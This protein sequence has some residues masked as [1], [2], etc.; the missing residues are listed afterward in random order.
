V[1][2]LGEILKLWEE[3]AR[4]GRPAVLATVVKITGSAYRRPGARMIFPSDRAPAGIVSGGCLEEDLAERARDVLSSGEPSIEVYDMRSPDDI[5]WGL[6][7]GCNG[8]IRVLLEKLS[9]DGAC[10]QMAFLRECRERGRRGVMVTV[11]QVEGEMDVAVGDRLMLRPD[12]GP[13][14]SITGSGIFPRVADDAAVCLSD[15][16]SRVERYEAE[17]GH[18]EALIEHVSAPVSLIIFGAGSDARPLARLAKELGWDV[19]VIDNRPAYATPEHFPEADGVRICEYDKL[20]RAGLEIDERTPVVVMTHH[21]LRDLEIL[22]F[23][24][25]KA[26]PYIGLLG[27]RKRTEKLLQELRARGFEREVARPSVL[28][29]PVGVDIGSETPEEIALSILAEIQAVL[30]GRPG[31]FLKD[32]REPLHDWPA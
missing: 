31:G 17:S 28:H 20:D 26:S 9:P 16:R 22:R 14:G 8:E 32:R 13:G 4:Q 12:G 6:G 18:A 2:E 1:K 23:L 5:V 27:P 30:A 21:F 10:E 29:G 3:T 7:L 19:T 15:R 25:P 11:F 24:I